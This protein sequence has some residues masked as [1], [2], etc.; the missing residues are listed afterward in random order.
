MN[1][2]QRPRAKDTIAIWGWPLAFTVGVLLAFS[3]AISAPFVFDDHPSIRLN[4]SISQ[5]ASSLA[6]PANT[7]VAGRPAVNVAFA[8]NRA[9]NELFGVNP[10]GPNATTGYHL[11]NLALHL[12]AGLLLFGLLRR[13]LRHASS[14]TA[15][16]ETTTSAWREHE[17]LAVAGA[18]TLLWL[19]HPIQ[20][21][22]VDYL[23]QRTE[24][25]VSICYLA[26]LY[27]ALRAWDSAHH[28]RRWRVGAVMACVVG[29]FSKEVM[30]SAPLL[31][32]L[33]DRAFRV[34]SWRELVAERERRI[35]YG[36]LVLSAAIVVGSVLSRARY[37]TVG[38]NLGITWYEYFYTQCWA[39]AH[40]LRLM[41]WP[42]A[43]NFDYGEQPV[44]GL[45]GLPGL[46][47]LLTLGV[48][49]VRCWFSPRLH[50]LG[51][52]GA[53]FFCL[54]APSSSFVPIK[55][56]VAAERRIYLASAAVIVLT[57]LSVRALWHR[58]KLPSAALTVLFVT[59]ALSLACATFVR[60]QTYTDIERLYR[61]AMQKSPNNARVY[62]GVGMML[63]AKGPSDAPEAQRLL[64]RAV[65]LDS[66]YVSGWQALGLL[67]VMNQQWPMAKRAYSAAMR[68]Q[69]GNPDAQRGLLQ[70]LIG[71]GDVNGARSVVDQTP[72]VDRSALWSVGALLVD[73]QRGAEALPYLE[74]AAR[75]GLTPAEMALMSVALAEANRTSNAVAAAKAAASVSNDSAHVLQVLGRAMI[76]ARHKAEAQQYLERALALQ[77][78][79]AETRRLL[80]SLG[81]MR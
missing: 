7:S 29:M 26:T 81:A 18:T 68:L 69:P 19:L 35:F 45:A 74:R 22:A 54:L 49:T 4:A 60:G 3:S 57:V 37:T 23:T 36:A 28:A 15:G 58:W 47:L 76:I 41:F 25:L 43:L 77:S 17:A 51:V 79:S 11:G 55:T 62:A 1:S 20:T 63:M 14:D 32:L 30:I 27:C 80:D 48:A 70:S 21:E 67:Y 33:Y 53:W 65:T 2:M 38:F 50:W 8:L 46:L 52:L 66:N 12:T 71:L 56:E 42:N 10:A 6:P 64:E 72:D 34:R 24:I 13:T 5:L 44:R 16:G 39:I 75:N 59:S 78:T 73:K 9:L 40:Y 61:D 31:V